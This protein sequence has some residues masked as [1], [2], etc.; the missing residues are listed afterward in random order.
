[1]S[2]QKCIDS[3]SN[4]S[5]EKSQPLPLSDVIDHISLITTFADGTNEFFCSL[6]KSSTDFHLFVDREERMG[7]NAVH[8]IP[9][10]KPHEC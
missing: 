9:L 10:L 3:S 2:L 5:M 8:L 4:T 6:F 1:M 7:C